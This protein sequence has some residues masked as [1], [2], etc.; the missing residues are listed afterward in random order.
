M[1]Y[2]EIAQPKPYY[3]RVHIHPKQVT[4][5]KNGETT[6]DFTESTDGDGKELTYP[7]CIRKTSRYAHVA[8]SIFGMSGFSKNEATIIFRCQHIFRNLFSRKPS[9]YYNPKL[10]DIFTQE[11][12][13]RFISGKDYNIVPHR[14]YT[15]K[16]RKST[17]INTS[18]NTNTNMNPTPK[19]KAIQFFQSKIGTVDI[20]ISAPLLGS[21]KFLQFG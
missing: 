15:I 17:T 3:D 20:K 10:F 2:I 5:L 14:D 8:Y 12:I 18:T 1:F 9:R 7:C 19:P 16:P 6:I 4:Q 11:Q 13:P 21:Q